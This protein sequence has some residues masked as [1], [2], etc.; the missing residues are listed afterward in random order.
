LRWVRFVGW[1]EGFSGWAAGLRWVRLY[2]IVI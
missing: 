2:V 1:R